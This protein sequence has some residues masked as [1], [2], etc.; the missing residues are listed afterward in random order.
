LNADGIANLQEDTTYVSP[1]TP[2]APRSLKAALE[3]VTDS[4]RS[5]NGSDT[6]SETASEE[7]YD[8]LKH[9]PSAVV[10]GGRGGGFVA[11]THGAKRSDTG[12]IYEGLKVS[13]SKSRPG[14]PR[15]KTIPVT[16]NKLKEKGRYVLTADDDA[17]REILKVSIERVRKPASI[18][19]T[20]L[21]FDRRKILL[22]SE[23][24]SSVTWFSHV[25]S[26]LLIGTIR[27]VRTRLSM[28]SSPSS[29]SEQLSSWRR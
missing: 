24:A 17:L 9:D 28:A 15:L 2:G 13:S 21:T 14:P 12:K 19:G 5:T 7:D 16:L 27:T 11:E 10:A 23:G 22:E 26:R 25:N 29:G 20:L 3:A 8:A 6:A 4:G 1:T 18:L